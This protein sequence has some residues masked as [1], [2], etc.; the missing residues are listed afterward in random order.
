MPKAALDRM[1][2]D[3]SGFTKQRNANSSR[4]A[5]RMRKLKREWMKE[6]GQAGSLEMEDAILAIQV[7]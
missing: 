1:I 2:D 5:R 4:I 6:T 3:A 7:E